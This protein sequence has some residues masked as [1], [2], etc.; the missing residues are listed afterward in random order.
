[1]SNLTDE[2]RI[3]EARG[4]GVIS[5]DVAPRSGFTVPPRD[6]TVPAPRPGGLGYRIVKRV[7]DVVFSVGVVSVLAIPTAVVCASPN[8]RPIIISFKG[9][10]ILILDLSNLEGLFLE[11]FCVHTKL[12]EV[13][14]S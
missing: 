1:M 10:S 9:Y 4:E 3:R 13:I 7:F 12:N 8:N 2:N 14:R 11:I 6:D 5:G